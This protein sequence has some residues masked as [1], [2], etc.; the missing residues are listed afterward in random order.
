M[1]PYQHFVPSRTKLSN[2]AARIGPHRLRSF[3]Q[4]VVATARFEAVTEAIV[5]AQQRRY[6]RPCPPA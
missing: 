1:R 6:R 2:L 5:D 3:E 4:P